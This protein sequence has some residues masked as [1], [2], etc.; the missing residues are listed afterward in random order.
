MN[1]RMIY[2][3]VCCLSLF[4]SGC[5]TGF[6]GGS[7]TP[8][9]STFTPGHQAL[10]KSE[11]ETSGYGLYSYVLFPAPA[12]DDTR[13]LYLQ[14]IKACLKTKSVETLQRSGLSLNQLHVIYL[15]VLQNP[16]TLSQ[17]KIEQMD[18]QQWSEWVLDQYDFSRAKDILNQLPRVQGRGPFIVSTKLPVSVS[19]LRARDHMLQDLSSIPATNP[20]VAFFWVRDFLSLASDSQEWQTRLRHFTK[21]VQNQISATI[22]K[23]NFRPQRP[24]TEFISIYEPQL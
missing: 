3:L 16:R 8:F 15:P 19:P 10:I 7:R 14:T 24:I 21:N 5:G 17:N 18:L 11:K 13:N 9:H 2:I 22:Q 6:Q 4:L 12:T 23:R 1:V 20:N